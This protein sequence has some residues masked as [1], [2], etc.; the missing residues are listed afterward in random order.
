VQDADEEGPAHVQPAVAINATCF[1]SLFKKKLMRER[2]APT[3]S[4]SALRLIFGM[5]VAGSSSFAK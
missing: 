2:V 5:I 3:I 1:W 4:A